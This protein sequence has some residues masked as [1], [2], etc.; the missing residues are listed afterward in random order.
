MTFYTPKN[1]LLKKYL[2]GYYFISGDE[3]LHYYTFP[4]NYFILSLNLDSHIELS[5][6]RIVV[7]DSPEKNFLADY[8]ARYT[9][10]IEILYQGGAQEIT[11][12]FLPSAIHH[13]VPDAERLLEKSY[14][15]D[16]NPYPDFVDAM[17]GA[18]ALQNLEEKR[19]HLENYWLSKFKEQPQTQLQTLLRYLDSP[20]KLEAIAE[21]MGISSQYLN[22]LFTRYIGKSPSEYRKIQ[23]FRAAI[24][25]KAQH[26]NLTELSHESLFYDQSHLI[27]DFKQFT[28]EKPQTFF[29]KVDPQKENLWLFI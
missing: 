27:K 11:F 1:E 14:A 6:N 29:K 25:R 3:K 7:K 9:A 10:P 17:K 28:Q 2:A 20:L 12:Y 5:Q 19:D 23:R 16:F 13:F 8:Y 22:K 15:P 18:F 24:Q 26:K 21:E 4:N